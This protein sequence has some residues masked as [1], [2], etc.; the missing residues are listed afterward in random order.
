MRGGPAVWSGLISLFRQVQLL[1][2]QF[3]LGALL[4]ACSP[5]YLVALPDGGTIPYIPAHDGGVVVAFDGGFTACLPN[6]DCL[7]DAGTCHAGFQ[8]CLPSG[9]LGPCTAYASCP[10]PESTCTGFVDIV[11]ILDDSAQDVS[12]A[13]FI[14]VQQAISTFVWENQQWNYLYAVEDVPGCDDGGWEPYGAQGLERAAAF[15]PFISVQCVTNG[16]AGNLAVTL[17][18]VLDYTPW[19]APNG[20]LSGKFV[21]VFQSGDFQE[22]DYV[23]QGVHVSVMGYGQ[24]TTDE[25]FNRLTRDVVC[26]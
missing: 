24:N 12:A 21:F 10:P 13:D 4:A 5:V 9:V 20:Q 26:E 7:V 23:T 18:D 6:P 16:P 2:P 1:A 19:V 25:V 14:V 3:F 22:T 15:L 11:F 17:T 8:E